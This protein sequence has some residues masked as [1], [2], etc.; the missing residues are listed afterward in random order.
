MLEHKGVLMIPQ[1]LII[2]IVCTNF[3]CALAL[4]G[5]HQKINVF[6]NLVTSIILITILAKGGFFKV[7][8]G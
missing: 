6:V 8:F 3:G 7:F 2:G 1:I 5:K 4:H